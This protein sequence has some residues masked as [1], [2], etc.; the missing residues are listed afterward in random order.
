MK[1]DNLTINGQV[2]LEHVARYLAKLLG[3]PEV[4]I[5]LSFTQPIAGVAEPL[6]SQQMEVCT[7]A[8]LREMWTGYA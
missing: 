7:V 4:S 1:H 8:D 5:N 6:E 2:K 3:V